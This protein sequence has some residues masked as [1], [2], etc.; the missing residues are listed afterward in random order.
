MKIVAAVLIISVIA[1]GQGYRIEQADYSREVKMSESTVKITTGHYTTLEDYLKNGGT[2][3]LYYLQ[4]L[5]YFNKTIVEVSEI[6]KVGDDYYFRVYGNNEPLLY[7]KPRAG[8]N[9][10]YVE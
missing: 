7:E 5:R 8:L 10:M 3:R 9:L 1:L 6:I 4:N 2:E